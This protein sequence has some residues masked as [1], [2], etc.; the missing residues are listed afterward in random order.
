MLPSYVN[1][2]DVYY[3]LLLCS[4]NRCLPAWLLFDAPVCCLKPLQ[5]GSGWHRQ[6]S[7]GS[8]PQLPLHLS[9]CSESS[10]LSG[11]KTISLT[12]GALPTI[13]LV[14]CDSSSLLVSGLQKRGKARGCKLAGPIGYSRM[15]E[16]RSL[17]F[18]VTDWPGS[19]LLGPGTDFI[20][21]LP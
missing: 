19:L 13:S 3:I 7:W 9:A 2:Q 11:G 17:P 16:K 6:D 5:A 21:H 14:V 20:W 18:C 10:A 1:F 8:L 12:S 4:S 15:G